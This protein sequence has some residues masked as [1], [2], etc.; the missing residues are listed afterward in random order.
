MLGFLA[1][2]DGFG[3]PVFGVTNNQQ[4]DAVWLDPFGLPH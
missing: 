3:N 1:E 2:D 4:T